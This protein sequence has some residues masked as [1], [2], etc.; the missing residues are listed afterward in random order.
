MDTLKEDIDEAK[1]RL[2]AWWDHEIIDRPVI[3]YY[4][5]RNGSSIAGFFDI[6]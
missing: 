6:I 5:P 2:E 3:S 1:N 4:F